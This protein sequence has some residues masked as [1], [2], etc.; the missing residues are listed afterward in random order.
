MILVE[1]VLAPGNLCTGRT[2]DPLEDK[3]SGGGRIA[4]LSLGPP[5]SNE[6]LTFLEEDPEDGALF[7]V[8]PN[9]CGNPCLKLK[10]PG[11]S[12][13]SSV[14]LT[15]SEVEDP[16]VYVYVVSGATSGWKMSLVKMIEGGKAG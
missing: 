1:L 15:V 9:Q 8:L 7:C 6:P 5:P 13:L 14:A 11:G 16:V 12:L 10:P 3:S 4:S 2:E